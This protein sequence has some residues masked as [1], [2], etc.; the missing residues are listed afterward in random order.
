MRTA[1]AGGMGTTISARLRG[2]PSYQTKLSIV[3]EHYCVVFAENKS[4]QT[5]H[6][7]MG[8]RCGWENDGK[9]IAKMQCRKEIADMKMPQ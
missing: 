8:Q 6:D 7:L 3:S 9:E 1:D 2:Q 4:E 5:V